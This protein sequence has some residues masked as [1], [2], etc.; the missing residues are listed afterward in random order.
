MPEPQIM[1]SIFVIQGHRFFFY[2]NEGDPREPMHV[3][4]RKGGGDAKVRI[5]P[6]VALA[7]SHGFSARE[8]RFIVETVEARRS[9]IRSMWNDHVGD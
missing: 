5:E 2:F 3:H 7:D 8:L 9:M 1:P 6:S 4:M